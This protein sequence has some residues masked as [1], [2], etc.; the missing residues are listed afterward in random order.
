MHT[1]QEDKK[2]IRLENYYWD[3]KEVG[4]LNNILAVQYPWR[5]LFVRVNAVFKLFD[6]LFIF[7][8]FV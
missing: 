4:I 8:S 7:C 6:C 3:K 1:I 2:Q 5:C